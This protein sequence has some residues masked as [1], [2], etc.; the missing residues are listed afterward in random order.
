MKAYSINKELTMNTVEQIKDFKRNFTLNN[1][2]GRFIEFRQT[3]SDFGEPIIEAIFENREIIL[4][5]IEYL[6]ESN[7]DSFVRQ[8]DGTEDFNVYQRLYFGV[9]FHRMEL[10]LVTKDEKMFGVVL[11]DYF[12]DDDDVNA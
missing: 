9:G 4:S 3:L 1:I 2:L 11:F 10:I 12:Y 5:D 8:I 6:H 7:K